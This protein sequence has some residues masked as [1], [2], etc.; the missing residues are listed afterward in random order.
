MTFAGFLAYAGALAIAVAIPGPGVTALIARTLGSGF[1]PALAMLFGIVL[2][3]LFYLTAVVLGLALIAQ[4]FGLLFLAVKWLGVAYL[5]WLA[6]KFW[7]IGIT[8]EQVEAK[9]GSTNPVS[10]LLGGLTL[11]LGNPKAMIFYLAITPTIV[12]LKAITLADYAVLAA[13]TA[14]MLIVVLLPYIV[15]AAKARGLLKSPGGLKFLSRGAAVFMFGA[16]T[17]IAAR[18]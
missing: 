1:R 2:G 4:T 18:Q 13:L 7:S 5:A 10:N 12:D 17:A 15:L 8:P 3:D 16:A 14:G 9:H 6:W 11:T